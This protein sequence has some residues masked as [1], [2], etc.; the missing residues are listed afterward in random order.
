[1]ALFRRIFG[2]NSTQTFTVF[3]QRMSE[4]LHQLPPSPSKLYNFLTFLGPAS[5]F[6]Q[7]TFYP[8]LRH[9]FRS[10]SSALRQPP[11]NVVA[12]DPNQRREA[13]ILWMEEEALSLCIHEI[14]SVITMQNVVVVFTI[15]LSVHH[16]TRQKA[17][18]MFRQ[19]LNYKALYSKLHAFLFTPSPQHSCQPWYN[20]TPILWARLLYLLSSFLESSSTSSCDHNLNFSYSS[21]LPS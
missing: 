4:F 7:N 9:S 17:A 10:L 13:R 2:F 19:L 14:H 3:S 20:N 8:V 21:G 6:R 16:H 12:S 11:S 1:M 18:T 5:S 15:F